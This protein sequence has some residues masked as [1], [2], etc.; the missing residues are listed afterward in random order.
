MD[1]GH[2]A[3]GGMKMGLWGLV[4]LLA[5]SPASAACEY[6]RASFKLDKCTEVDS[7]NLSSDNPYEKE[8][9]LPEFVEESQKKYVRVV[10]RCEYSLKGSGGVF[11]DMDS[12][13]EKNETW[14]TEDP[15]AVCRRG[16][17]LCRELCPKTLP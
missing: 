10:C 13:I 15:D 11:C 1:H 9:E 4:L 17:S 3:S 7:K 14:P 6:F 8:N 5:A 2:E 16:K 12:W